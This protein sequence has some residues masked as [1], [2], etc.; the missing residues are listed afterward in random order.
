MRVGNFPDVG[1]GYLYAL[2]KLTPYKQMVFEPCAGY[3]P[4]QVTP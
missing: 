4:K 2:I 3:N 1:L